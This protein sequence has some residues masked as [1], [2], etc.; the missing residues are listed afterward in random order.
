MKR[1]FPMLTCKLCA[2]FNNKLIFMY[3][4]SKVRYRLC[5]GMQFIFK[6]LQKELRKIYRHTM[7]ASDHFFSLRVKFELAYYA[8]HYFIALFDMLE[9]FISVK[10]NIIDLTLR[11]YTLRPR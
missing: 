11:S 1:A 3:Y 10:I 5:C 7:Y 6:W 9:V 8:K 4:K 2:K